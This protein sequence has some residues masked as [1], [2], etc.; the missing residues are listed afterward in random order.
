MNVADSFVLICG[1]FGGCS[2][3]EV[4]ALLEVDNVQF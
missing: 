4:E 3:G 2:A 1:D